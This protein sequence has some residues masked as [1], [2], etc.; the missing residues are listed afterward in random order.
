ME[1]EMELKESI[2]GEVGR[3][4]STYNAINLAQGYPDFI[5]EGGVE[6]LLSHIRDWK[7]HQYTDPSGVYALKESIARVTRELY[8]VL[9]DPNDNVVITAGATQAI[10]NALSSLLNRGDEAIVLEPC[11]EC[12]AP[13]I[14]FV[15][16]HVKRVRL[17]YNGTIDW[18]KIRD[19]ITDKVKL[20]VVNSPHNPTGT[21]WSAEDI[22]IF[23]DIM[24]QKNIWV[25][26]DEVYHTT[27]YEPNRHIC[28]WENEKLRERTVVIG[29]IGKMLGSTGWRLGYSLANKHIT[30]KIINFQQYTTYS[31]NTLSQYAATSVLNHDGFIEENRKFYQ[32]KRDF[33]LA[34]VKKTR[35]SLE[36][37][38]GTIFQILDYSG[39]SD[40]TS[41]EYSLDLLKNHGIACLPISAFIEAPDNSKKIR[42]CFA[43]SNKTLERAIAILVGI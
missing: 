38:Q 22:S 34:G 36:K 13:A 21:C 41:K 28:L 12:Y 5:Q 16:G 6:S 8:K 18:D 3:L 11:F 19:A 39:I 2:F 37:S 31:T 7:A 24:D 4:S 26:S 10:F 43:K 17:N 32:Q 9:V 42:L 1:I 30:K 14:N 35:F 33:F 25:I 29:S 27:V 40:K 20:I 15:G 23:A